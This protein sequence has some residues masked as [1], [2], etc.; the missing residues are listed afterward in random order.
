M[1]R[2]IL[3]ILVLGL[4]AGCAAEA[5]KEATKLSLACQMSRCDCASDVMALFDTEPVQ[6]KSDGRASCPE[7]Y[8]LRRLSPALANPS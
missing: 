6:W 3:S 7:G 5:E 4:V 8:H 2:A 1:Q